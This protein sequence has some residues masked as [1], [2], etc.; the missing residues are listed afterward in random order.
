MSEEPTKPSA[1]VKTQVYLSV[2]EKQEMERTASANGRTLSEEIRH[3]CN[4]AEK[5]SPRERQMIELVI[6]E[7]KK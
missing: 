5:L 7:L 3:R 6:A 2:E 1:R 4:I